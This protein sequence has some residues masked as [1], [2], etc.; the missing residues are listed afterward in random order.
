MWGLPDGHSVLL[1]WKP[2]AE[3]NFEL[4][5]YFYYNCVCIAASLFFAL[6]AGI[7]LRFM[8]DE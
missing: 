8:A 7:V 3:A 5:E 2:A 1:D 6:S 4:N